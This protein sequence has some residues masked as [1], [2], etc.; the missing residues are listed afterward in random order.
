MWLNQ[1]R[2]VPLGT[3]VLE[4]A[5]HSRLG[6]GKATRCSKEDITT[7]LISNDVHRGTCPLLL[8]SPRWHLEL[9]NATPSFQTASAGSGELYMSYLIEHTY[10]R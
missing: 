3:V 8:D 7:R 2:L 6:R 1:E 4:G 5:V 9:D 10:D